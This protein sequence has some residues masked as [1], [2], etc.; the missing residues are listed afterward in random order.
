MASWWQKIT[1]RQPSHADELADVSARLDELKKQGG[2]EIDA[3]PHCNNNRSELAASE[4]ASC[5]Y[6][7]E[8][9]DPKEVKDWV[10]RNDTA[11]CTKCGI[12]SVIGAASGFPV[13]NPKF[14]EQ[15]REKWFECSKLKTSPPQT[16][17]RQTRRHS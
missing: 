13:G 5:F 12:D 11:L 3:H 16:P 14:L 15:M 2:P 6:C 17:P 4:I 10:D 8:I 1:G 7:C 9:F